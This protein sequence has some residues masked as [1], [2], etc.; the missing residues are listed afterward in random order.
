VI[1]PNF[2]LHSRKN[3]IWN[4]SGMDSLDK[5]PDVNHFKNY[6]HQIVYNYNS[7]GFRDAEWPTT[8]EELQDSIWCVG[9]S[10]TVGIGSPVQHTWSNILQRN[11]NK[12][13]INVS[14]DGASNKWIARK[15]IDILQTIRPKLII[16]QWSYIIRDELPDTTLRDEDRRLVF[17]DKIRNFNDVMIDS[18]KLITN[19]DAQK[20]NC[21]IIHSFVPD[22]MCLN[23]AHI[24]E[25]WGHVADSKWPQIP[26]NLNEFN[27]LSKNIISEL[28]H[29]KLYE[30]LSLYYQLKNNINHI[31]EITRLDLSRD[32]YHYDIITATAFVAQ[33]E[34]LIADL[35]L[36]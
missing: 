19:V 4:E 8:I 25:V 30:L 9:D 3:E 2:I 29:F 14:M 11:T 31:P 22:S 10:F 23:Y 21:E 27:C 35:Q 28:H 1:L 32:G 26:K 18:F 13:C 36:T 24:V 16:I 15:A 20:N 33:L 12:R 7:R 6:P 34:N 5:C 17:Y